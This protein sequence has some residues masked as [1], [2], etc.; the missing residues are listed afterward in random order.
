[1]GAD[2]VYKMVQ[3]MVHDKVPIDGVGMQAHL[4]VDDYQSITSGGIY[5]NLKR[6][7]DLGLEIHITELDV[8]CGKS[9]S[10]DTLRQQAE[11]Y[12]TILRAC[13]A[14][15]TCKSFETWGFTDKYTWK[16]TD[17]R[18]LPWDT[19]YKA[20]MAAYYIE[21]ELMKK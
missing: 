7:A 14:V 5:A 8:A 19:Q 16:G 10:N 13:L 4:S 21:S 12:Q 2:A 6:F 3:Q 18:P 15:N 17:Q 11:L 9:V 1:M 20:K